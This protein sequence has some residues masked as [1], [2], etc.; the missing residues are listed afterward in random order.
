MD[1]AEEDGHAAGRV[2]QKLRTRQAIVEAAIQMAREGRPLSIAEVAEAALVSTATAYRYFP[3]PQSLW[4]E[5]AKDGRRELSVASVM[6]GA[7]ADP[8]GRMD[9]VVRTTAELQ[10]GDEALWRAVVRSIMDRWFAQ[11]DVPE[12]ERIPIRGDRRITMTREALAGLAD[13]LPPDLHERLIS[14]VALVFGA[15]AVIS[16]RDV[17]ELEPDEVVATLRWSAQALIR[18]ARDQ[19][20]ERRDGELG[21][22]ERR[23]GERRDGERRDGEG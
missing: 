12:D 7:P 19:A 8:A 1:V 3:N 15:E 6:A 18:A 14:A 20:T 21:D 4:V 13:E 10:L 16:A 17:C 22:G 9:H 23:D 2:N 5:V 11:Q